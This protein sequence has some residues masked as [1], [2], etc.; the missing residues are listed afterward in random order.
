M[1]R[2]IYAEMPVYD[3]NSLEQA[4]NG[5]C[6]DNT[7]IG[8]AQDLKF[9]PYDCTLEARAKLPGVMPLGEQPYLLR[10]PDFAGQMAIRLRLIQTKPVEVMA[11]KPDAEDAC[12]ELL[13]FVIE[14]LGYGY[15]ITPN[16][17]ERP[18]GMVVRRDAAPLEQLAVL[19]QEDF[20]LLDKIGE[21]HVLRAALLC[22]PAGWLLSQKMGRPLGTIHDPV[23]AY[24][25]DLARRI[26]RLFD[27]VQ[28]GRPLWR[29]NALEYHDPSLFQPEKTRSKMGDLPARYLRT[30]RQ[31]IFRLP[32][33][34]MVVFSIR[35]AVAP[36]GE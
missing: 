29:A 10:G 9:L 17:I 27:G 2:I 15:H 18:D 34:E 32:K 14:Q 23:E 36:L 33:S 13:G 6:L 26:Q 4:A 1:L 20:C 30:E 25:V 35:T 7:A 21:E 31:L 19:V 12:W 22:F 24:N 3:I 16:T 8:S 5:G 28:V 11:C